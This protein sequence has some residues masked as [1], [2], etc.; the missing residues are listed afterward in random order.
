LESATKTG[1]RDFDAAAADEIW[2]RALPPAVGE[3]PVGPL[4]PVV[5]ARILELCAQYL[6]TGAG[7]VLTEL[8]REVYPVAT[9][10]EHRLGHQTALRLL[11]DGISIA[12][13]QLAGSHSALAEQILLRVTDAAWQTHADMLQETIRRQQEERYQQELMVAKR[14]QERLLPRSVPQIPGFDIAGRV[15]PAAEVGGDYWSCRQYPED[16][17]VTLKLA[18][19]TGH[20]I[21][22]ATLVSA[23]KFISGGY[24]RGAK[25]A[26]QVMERT[27]AVLVRDTPH[28]IMVTMFY[29]WL[30]PE[31]SEMTVVNA[32]HSPVLH[33][34][35]ERFCVIPPTGPALGMVD[36]KYREVRLSMD[37]GDIL[38]TCSDGVTEPSAEVALGAAW[39]ERQVAENASLPAEELVSK[40][41]DSALAVYGTAR[42]DMSVLVVKRL[43]YADEAASR[44]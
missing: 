35:R 36:A 12:L 26:A 20:G 3:D 24:Y 39:V 17:I 30:Y 31:S 9:A 38:I 7:D 23:V 16:D 44:S 1:I 21:A 32:G 2:L 37:P 22:A 19:V 14:I 43:P 15:L 18:D 6:R 11:R 27:N 13:A 42:D 33:Y 40:I 10:L 8:D 34:H 5:R 25:T 28:E 29:G 41:I 4:G